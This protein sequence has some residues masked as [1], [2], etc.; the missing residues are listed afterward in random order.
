VSA[1]RSADPAEKRHYFRGGSVVLF[2]E[3]DISRDNDRNLGS[4][5]RRTDHCEL[6]TNASRPFPQALQAKVSFFT[7]IN[8]CRIDANA[9]VRDTHCEVLRV[10]D[11]DLQA[12]T[13]GV[14]TRIANCLIAN[15]ED[16]I[17]YNRMHFF[18]VTG[19]G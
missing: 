10:I 19:Y 3:N 14:H 1:R 8:H 17:A 9:I 4:S 7:F 13:A 6:G 18:G 11:S 15:P 2:S 12:T 5:I 16:F